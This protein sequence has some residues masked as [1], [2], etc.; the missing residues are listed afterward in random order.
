[1]VL[2]VVLERVERTELRTEGLEVPSSSKV[3]GLGERKRAPE[4]SELARACCP[5]S[6]RDMCLAAEELARR[7]AAANLSCSAEFTF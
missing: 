6:G 3:L 1:M 7:R 5:D 4:N 2:L